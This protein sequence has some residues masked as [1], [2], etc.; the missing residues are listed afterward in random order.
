MTHYIASINYDT[1]NLSLTSGVYEGVLKTNIGLDLPV[2]I[3]LT[4]YK[5]IV[6]RRYG[7]KIFDNY[8]VYA[9]GIVFCDFETED[10]RIN[11]GYI[12]IGNNRVKISIMNFRTYNL[13]L[14]TYD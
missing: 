4:E 8:T 5:R 7:S 14:V 3:I 10:I 12:I 9:K 11:W 1:N 13:K 6:K 2:T